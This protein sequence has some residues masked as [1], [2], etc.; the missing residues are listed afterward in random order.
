MTAAFPDEVTMHVS[1]VG[2]DPAGKVVTPRIVIVAKLLAKVRVPTMVV[3]LSGMAMENMFGIDR[4]TSFIEV[5]WLP[6][7][8]VIER[9]LVL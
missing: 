3:T 2:K 7:A 1:V 8:K 6:G 9:A 5:I 4:N